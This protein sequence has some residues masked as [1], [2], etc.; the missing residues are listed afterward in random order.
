MAPFTPFLADTI[1]L[2]LKEY[3]PADV[4]AKYTKDGRSVHFLSYPV[5]REE[6]F[7]EAIETAVARMQS[8]IDLGRNIR[9]KKMISLKTPLK[10]LVILHGDEASLSK[11]C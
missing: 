1:Y 7:D 3:I 10:T 9:E 8:V 6:L 5:V 11:G 2:K 4:L